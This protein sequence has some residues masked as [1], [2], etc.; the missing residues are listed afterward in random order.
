VGFTILIES[1]VLLPGLRTPE[2]KSRLLY[3][4]HQGSVMERQSELHLERQWELYRRSVAEGMPDSDY[5]AAV[6]AGIAHA[7]SRLDSIED[8]QR[9]PAK[10]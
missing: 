1:G 10:S 4:S 9:R 2:R 6:L 8:S 3:R 5:K 7:L